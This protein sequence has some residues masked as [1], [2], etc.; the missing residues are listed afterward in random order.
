M[1]F[2]TI[3]LLGILLLG[4]FPSMKAADPA[5][6][7]EVA[8]GF[9]GGSV[10]TSG[11]TG[12]CVWYL[13]LVGNLKLESLF[14][15]VSGAPVVDRQHAYLIWVS[16]FSVVRLPASGSFTYLFLAPVGTATIYFS[17]RPESRDWSNLTD[18]TSWG[19]PV[20]TFVRNAG[21]VQSADDLK[22]DTFIFSA[23]LV[24]S[25]TFTLNGKLFNFRSLIPHGMTCFETGENGSS[26][27][28]GT[29]IAVGGR[30]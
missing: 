13:P 1:K 14:E 28:A 18:R 29:C 3:A 5:G 19:E 20:A 15:T 30:W 11:S 4:S 27:E 21:L 12:I 17:N 6:A 9:T 2:A 8:I 24:S 26:S 7:S 16:D 10:W 23:D 25:K 22:S